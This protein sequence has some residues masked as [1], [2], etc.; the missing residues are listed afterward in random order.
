MNYKVYCLKGSI[1]I[2]FINIQLFIVVVV[3]VVVIVLLLL[4]GNAYYVLF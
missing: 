3:V 2:T 4:L 1:N